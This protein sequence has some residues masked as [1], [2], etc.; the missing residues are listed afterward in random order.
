M[1]RC[2]APDAVPPTGTAV[3]LSYNEE[4]S[5]RLIDVSPL[6]RRAGRAVMQTFPCALCC[7][8]RPPRSG[9]VKPYPRQESLPKE[10]SVRTNPLNDELAHRL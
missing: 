9:A 5:M 6:Q 1:P 3:A 2:P 7:W 8:S 4:P 10:L